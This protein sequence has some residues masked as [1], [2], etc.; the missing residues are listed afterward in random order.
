M[1]KWA[2]TNHSKIGQASAE[3]V[4]LIDTEASLT[5]NAFSVTTETLSPHLTHN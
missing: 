2:C 5:S 4:A 1:G 3:N